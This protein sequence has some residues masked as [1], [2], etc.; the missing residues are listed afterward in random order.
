MTVLRGEI[1]GNAGNGK[2]RRLPPSTELEPPAVKPT[3]VEK[4]AAPP[5]P[6]AAETAPR[7]EK[8]AAQYAAFDTQTADQGPQSIF[9]KI[10]DKVFKAA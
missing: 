10:F 3:V 5:T 9:R 2:P 1:N 7:A 4:K 6:A 8:K